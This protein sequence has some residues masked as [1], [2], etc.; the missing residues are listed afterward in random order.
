MDKEAFWWLVDSTEGEDLDSRYRSLVD[1]L[2]QLSTDEIHEFNLRWHEAHQAAYSWDLWGAAYLI[3]GGAS[4]DAFEY[5]RNW[6]ILQGSAVFGDA[7]ANPD[8]LA[9]RT[10]E[11]GD[12]NEEHEFEAYPALDAWEAATGRDLDAYYVSEAEALARL[13]LPSPQSATGG[14]PTGQEWDFDND[15]EARRRLPR[16]AER[17][18]RD[19]LTGVESESHTDA[20]IERVSELMRGLLANAER[21]FPDGVEVGTIGLV[22]EVNSTWVYT[23]VSDKRQWVQSGLFRAA[24]SIVERAFQYPPDPPG[25]PRE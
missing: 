15:Q 24:T 17:S 8:S 25:P 18:S 14:A 12:D 23:K 19:T 1:R 13:K 20:S 16:L 2:A 9:E 3:E 21:R 10:G 22:A 4:D 11:V 5:F 6:L 7:L